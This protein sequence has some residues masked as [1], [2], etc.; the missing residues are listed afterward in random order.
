[1]VINNLKLLELIVP[2]LNENLNL[3]MR[4]MEELIN[5][6]SRLGRQALAKKVDVTERTLRTTVDILREQGIVDVNRSGIALTSMGYD[7]YSLIQEQLGINPRIEKMEARLQEM[8]SLEHCRIVPGDADDS[9]QVFDELGKVVQEILNSQLPAGDQAITVGGG[10]TLAK[11]SHSFT[12]TLSI[13][14]QLTF[15]PSRGGDSDSLHVQANAVASMLAQ[16]THT[17]FS[18]LYLPDRISE[19][20]SK[21]LLDD[22]DIKR[23]IDMSRNAD[24]LLF[25]IG[26]ADV[27][28]HRRGLTSDQMDFIQKNQ[29]VGEAFGVFF[30]KEGSRILTLDRIGLKLEDIYRFSLLLIVVSG[31]SK[32]NATKAFFKGYPNRGWLICDEALATNVLNGIDPIKKNP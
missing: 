3:R 2:E 16:N 5:Y 21:V 32:A 11:I 10:S 24:G 4:V 1:M 12:P 14:R 28:A 9:P 22:P 23:K 17:N 18:P 15:Y 6:P 13:K 8:L 27:M 29:A 26:S 20:A 30:D 25:S 19:T 31:K 7:I